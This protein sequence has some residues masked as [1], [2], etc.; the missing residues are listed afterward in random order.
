V[1]SRSP[2]QCPTIAAVDYYATGDLMA[3]VDGAVF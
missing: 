1:P 3:L 2:P